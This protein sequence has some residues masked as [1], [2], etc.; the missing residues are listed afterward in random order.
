M[1]EGGNGGYPVM[2]KGGKCPYCGNKHIH[3]GPS[4][5]RIANCSSMPIETMR[6]GMK[7]VIKKGKFPSVIRSPFGP[8]RDRRDGYYW[9]DHN[10]NDMGDLFE[11]LVKEIGAEYGRFQS[12][13]SQMLGDLN[14]GKP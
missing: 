11:G 4:G 8:W 9:V 7:N 12:D 3:G 14:I 1:V 5:H 10:I 2:W 13:L 6:P